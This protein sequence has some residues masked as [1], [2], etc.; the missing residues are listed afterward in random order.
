MT[1]NFYFWIHRELQQNTWNKLN[2]IRPDSFDKFRRS[3]FQVVL[4]L[5]LH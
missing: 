2:R 5:M 1:Q 4:N 3:Y